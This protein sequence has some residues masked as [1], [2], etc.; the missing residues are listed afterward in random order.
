MIT[1]RSLPIYLALGF[2]L[3]ALVAWVSADEDY[4]KTLGV[5]RNADATQIKKAY[6]DLSKKWHPDKNPGNSEAEEK[7]AQINSAYEVL[8]DEEKRRTYDQ[9]GEDGLKKQAGGRGGG[10]WNPFADFFGGGFGG[11]HGET[12][13]RGPEI[14]LPV[15]VELKD[16]YNGREVRVTNRRQ[17]LCTECRGSGAENP[18]DVKTCHECG[19][20]GVKIVKKQLGPGF[21]QQMQVHCDA[22][23]G[24]G[25]VASSTCPHCGGSKVEIGEDTL[26]ISIERGMPDQHQ[27]VFN[28]AGDISPNTAPGDLKFTV[29]TVPDPNFSREGNDLHYTLRITLLEALV[30]YTREITHLDDHRVPI[31]R[32][33]VTI[34]GFTSKIK[35]EGMPHHE[36][37]SQ[38]GDLLVHH[39]IIFPRTL[40]EEQKSAFRELL[41]E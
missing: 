5:P 9:Y 30:G 32:S 38:R 33:K 1:Q 13:R 15:F 14:T 18:D 23:N 39:E 31:T 7:F 27:I 34:P 12:E 11:H 28:R 36:F 29:V 25:K 19:G 17:I 20:R 22:C 8:K 35:G 37:P 16:L 41:K 24:Q 40:T 2:C 10:G 21:I 4:Y 3:L 6:R 26:I